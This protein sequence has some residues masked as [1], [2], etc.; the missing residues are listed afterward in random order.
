MNISVKDVLREPIKHA[1]L[2]RNVDKRQAIIELLK[3]QQSV[4][5]KYGCG[6]YIND[7]DINEIKN[8]W[9]DGDCFIVWNRIVD[10]IIFNKEEGFSVHLQP[11][12]VIGIINKN[13]R[14]ILKLEDDI[15]YHCSYAKRHGL[16]RED[17][18]DDS[19]VEN[20]MYWLELLEGE[21]FLTNDDYI[22]LLINI[23]NKYAFDGGE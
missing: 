4:V 5:D 23:Y 16:C 7:D 9:S 3:Y 6:T 22:Q 2:F 20:C 15:C 8:E 21:I 12:C 14:H 1:I 10:S 19:K 18:S 13:I 11:W 17:D